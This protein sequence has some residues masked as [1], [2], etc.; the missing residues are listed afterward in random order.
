MVWKFAFIP[1]AVAVAGAVWT[2]FRRPSPTT[3]G[4]IQHFAAGV[5]FFAAAG[6]LLPD[7]LRQ[8]TVWPI[9]IGGALGVVAMLLLRSLGRRAGE[10]P[11]GLIAASGADALVDGIVL[12]LGFEAGQH[13]GM[14]LAVALAI[15]FLFLGLSVSGSFAEGAARAKVV[16]ASVGISLAVPLGTLL[17]KPLASLSRFWR[18]SAFSFG[19]VALLYLV[20]EELLT[21]A[22]EKPETPWGATM[23]SAGFLILMVLDQTIR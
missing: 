23:F 16:G 6:E 21:E 19:L 3:I 2:S 13:Q 9:V 14:L 17:S 20:T 4:A 22:H 7:A 8:G 1:V 18:G 10:G 15:E 11:T 12:G 5:I